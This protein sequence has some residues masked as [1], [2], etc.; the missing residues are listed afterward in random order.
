M[1][2][3]SPQGLGS[4]T[5]VAPLG[6]VLR[7][8]SFIGSSLVESLAKLSLVDGVWVTEE[9]QAW[10]CTTCKEK[11][12]ERVCEHVLMPPS[13]EREQND[14][15]QANASRKMGKETAKSRLPPVQFDFQRWFGNRSFRV[16]EIPLSAQLFLS[17]RER[18]ATFP[19]SKPLLSGFRRS[20]E[21]PRPRTAPGRNALAA[22]KTKPRSAG[23]AQGRKGAVG[24]LPDG[25][26]SG[27]GGEGKEFFLGR[28][29]SPPAAASDLR[30]EP[31]PGERPRIAGPRRQCVRPVSSGRETF[32]ILPAGSSAFFISIIII[33]IISF[34]KIFFYSPLLNPP[35]AFFF[36]FPFPKVR[37]KRN[38]PRCRR[39]EHQSD[40]FRKSPAEPMPR[41]PSERRGDPQSPSPGPAPLPAVPAPR[42]RGRGRRRCRPPAIRLPRGTAVPAPHTASARGAPRGEAPRIL[43][44]SGP[45]RCPGAPRVPPPSGSEAG[46]G[47]EGLP[48]AAVTAADPLCPAASRRTRRSPAR[49]QRCWPSPAFCLL[50]SSISS[51]GSGTRS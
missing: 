22:E 45:E 28:K 42:S 12:Q 27:N 37:R 40:F 30:G 51:V 3:W 46:A 1:V 32:Q 26:T 15:L 19:R 4:V 2:S 10:C 49:D 9:I 6:L 16:Y 36:S 38:K 18:N 39:T 7:Q 13:K 23:V 35:P 21:Q 14:T 41:S 20:P 17:E 43:R 33:I 47:L 31:R 8:S 50:L 34:F 24:F 44:E 48:E 25:R 29:L 11:G 5:W